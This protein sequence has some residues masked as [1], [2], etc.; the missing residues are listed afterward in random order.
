[1]TRRER[2][3]FV[4]EVGALSI[5]VVGLVFSTFTDWQ[6]IK[7]NR[8]Q[9]N[10]LSLKYT[11]L[12]EKESSLE[13]EVIKLEDEDYLARYAREKYYYSKDGELIIR[14]PEDE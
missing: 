1:M 11:S 14:V 9:K 8:E 10:E 13:S 12:L 3:R 2:R 6:T 4:V 5:L 7:Y